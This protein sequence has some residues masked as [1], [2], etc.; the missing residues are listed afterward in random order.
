MGG[1]QTA[2]SVRRSYAK[3][4]K[5]RFEPVAM[6]EVSVAEFQALKKARTEGWIEYADRLKIV[7]P[8]SLF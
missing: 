4:L 7:W 1:M 3:A 5:D 8:K 2:Y 6:K